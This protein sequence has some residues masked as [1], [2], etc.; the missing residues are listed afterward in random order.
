MIKRLLSLTTV[1]LL[2][3]QISTFGDSVFTREDAIQMALEANPALNQAREALKSKTGAMWQVR[4]QL[5]PKVS[6]FAQQNWFEYSTLD[7][8][9]L[10]GVPREQL[11]A[12]VPPVAL[13]SRSFGLDIRQTVFNGLANVNRYRQYDFLKDASYWQ[14]LSTGYNVISQLEQIYD[15]ILLKKAQLA[16]LESNVK[17]FTK[18]QEVIMK[19]EAAGDRTQLDGLRVKTELQRLIANEARVKSDLIAGEEALRKL[20]QMPTD[21]LSPEP[22]ILEGELTKRFFS[23]PLDEAIYRASQ[24]HPEIR[25]AIL[26]RDAAKAAYRAAQGAYLPTVDAF[27]RYA[28]NTSSST[29]DYRLKGWTVGLSGN[30][31]IFDGLGRE[32][33]VKT[34]KAELMNAEIGLS[35]QRYQII[36]RVRQLY[37]QQD[38]LDKALEAR[39]EA[40]RVAQR[41]V[42]ESFKSYNLG[43]I[44]I[45]T[46]IG[47]EQASRDA[48]LEYYQGLF[49]YNSVIYQTEYTVCM[50]PVHP[51][52]ITETVMSN[53]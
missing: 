17:S 32:G 30:W 40:V 2:V 33:A 24:L 14:L 37:A 4:A 13:N 50:E 36:S 16:T 27:A 51:V 46:M 6:A 44:D 45:E 10:N 5:L 19:R 22:L 39:L 12:G 31:L 25:S 20:L 34:Q 9:A 38:A 41:A 53:S 1:L 42:D 26:S 43:A 7:R 48:W 23:L 29:T 18:L 47:A 28:V 21:D 8:G 49:D 52:K 3:F 11:P 15:N 35:D